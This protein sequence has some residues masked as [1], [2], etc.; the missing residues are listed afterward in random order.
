MQILSNKVENHSMK[1]SNVIDFITFPEKLIP[2]VIF[3]ANSFA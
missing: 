2:K 1:Q 3:N